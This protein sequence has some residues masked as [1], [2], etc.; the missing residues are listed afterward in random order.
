MTVGGLTA[1]CDR[2][3]L[4]LFPAVATLGG[5]LS[6]LT[7][8][9]SPLGE[10]FRLLETPDL[11]IGIVVGTGDS[12]TGTDSTGPPVR[13]SPLRFGPHAERLLW[14]LHG[15]VLRTKS[16]R[17]LVSDREVSSALWPSPSA[18]PPAHW[19]SDIAVLFQSLL[20]L[21]V[22]ASDANDD[23]F[24]P[25]TRLLT[26]AEDLRR[27]PAQDLCPDG[28]P[29]RG[30]GAHHHYLIQLGPA[31]LG[32]L[33]DC[34]LKA[35]TG[36]SREYNFYHRRTLGRLSRQNRL[37]SVFLPAKLGAPGRTAALSPGQHR[38][39]QA[40]LQEVTRVP[41]RQRNQPVEHQV[42]TAG[43]IP[44]F[45]REL[46]R[47]PLL[48]PAQELIAFGGNG[49]RRG[50]GYQI[51]SP[52][53]W[54][55]KA[56][57]DVEQPQDFL[58]DLLALAAVLGLRIIGATRLPGD[59]IPGADLLSMASTPSGR[60]NLRHV[61]LRV[62]AD[63]DYWTQWATFFEWGPPRT[64]DSPLAMLQVRFSTSG[65]SQRL[66]AQQVNLGPSLLCRYLSGSRRIPEDVFQRLMMFLA[67]G[68]D[69]ARSERGLTR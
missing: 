6:R 49:H 44:N 53:G 15:Q 8:W 51:A 30:M 60:Q 27:D 69:A 38:I 40:C 59:W 31:F 19:R 28:C 22:V 41:A 63:A 68:A 56:G 23:D 48:D 3:R 12:A 11:C 67:P 47:C 32:H 20:R 37:G 13:G 5:Q 2:T 64:S 66:L 35:G 54:C 46:T 9:H 29:S 50:L 21:R 62:Y 1:L 65:L 36:E 17:L 45:R 58:R 14:F 57:Y 26:R 4:Q 10:W 25:S 24:G 61:H 42:F 18:R 52:G 33:E 7:A 39:L 34:R 16:S 43:I 55:A